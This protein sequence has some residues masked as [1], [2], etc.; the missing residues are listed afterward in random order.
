MVRASATAEKR[1]LEVACAPESAPWH[2]LAFAA[3]VHLVPARDACRSR[4]WNSVTFPNIPFT[5]EVLQLPMLHAFECYLEAWKPVMC[6]V[7]IHLFVRLALFPSPS[8]T[9]TAMHLHPCTPVAGPVLLYLHT[10]PHRIQWHLRVPA[11]CLVH[12]STGQLLRW[13]QQA[14]TGNK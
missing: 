11:V 2:L 13:V 3:L 8:S 10:L 12:A 7:R 6:G 14:V 9:G 5:F 1:E 4:V